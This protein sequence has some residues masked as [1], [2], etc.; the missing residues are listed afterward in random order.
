MTNDNYHIPA[1]IE[2]AASGQTEQTADPRLGLAP[3]RGELFDNVDTGE[4]REHGNLPLNQALAIGDQI[5]QMREAARSD[6]D[7]AA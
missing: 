2:P 4:Y 6:L 1:D 3:A 7:S 5:E